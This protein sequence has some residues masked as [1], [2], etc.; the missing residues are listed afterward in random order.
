MLKKV[1]SFFTFGFEEA[2]KSK[3]ELIF[4]G[5]ATLLL[6][7]VIVFII[8][9]FSYEALVGIIV[10]LV[11]I[12]MILGFAYRRTIKPEE[13]IT[14]VN[15]KDRIGRFVYPGNWLILVLILVVLLGYVSFGQ[16]GFW[17]GLIS[18][19]LT[20]ISMGFRILMG[21]VVFF[22][23]AIII[24]FL[25]EEL[26]P[27][28]IDF[29]KPKKTEPETVTDPQAD[30]KKRNI[31]LWIL[32][33]VSIIVGVIFT[34]TLFSPPISQSGNENEEPQPIEQEE[35]V[36]EV[37]ES[38]E[39]DPQKPAS[40]EMT[41]TPTDIVIAPCLE[42]Y[43]VDGFVFPCEYTPKSEDS[44]A[45]VAE[46][47]YGTKEHSAAL[48]SHNRDNQG[49]YVEFWERQTII[50]LSTEEVIVS[51]YEECDDPCSLPNIPCTVLT[52]NSPNYKDISNSCYDTEV[53]SSFIKGNNPF[54]VQR[55]NDQEI[56]VPWILKS[57]YASI[58][59]LLEDLNKLLGEGKYQD[60]FE[61]LHTQ[62]Y[63]NFVKGKGEENYNPANDDSRVN[64][65][66]VDNFWRY[67][68]V[69]METLKRITPLSEEDEYWEVE[70]DI[71]RCREDVS[72][73]T[74]PKSTQDSNNSER[75]DRVT[76]VVVEGG[77]WLI[78]E[79]RKGADD[80]CPPK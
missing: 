18:L 57:S 41:E 31:G 73:I 60:A 30:T 25:S 24:P 69:D 80:H 16:P 59:K 32:F 49:R 53:F 12:L 70:V 52:D 44:Y 23:T 62:G 40:A 15:W 4:L 66:F 11:T 65:T 38:E 5:I 26:R 64:E 56:V 14:Q 22:I 78:D 74:V 42:Q 27:S 21:I 72:G 28:V 47:F 1:Q 29:L 34:A 50:L 58:K 20:P 35:E 55:G 51:P 48:I 3:R 68:C 75:L 45:A 36:E 43:D 2:K 8:I 46:E 7:A 77:N 6:V 13:E 39:I 19:S 76:C 33:G 61:D 17:N 54:P 63:K 9:D 10:I 71:Y 37:E 79:W 67:F